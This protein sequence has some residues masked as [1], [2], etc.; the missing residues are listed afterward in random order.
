MNTT[1]VHSSAE[2]EMD[3]ICWGQRWEHHRVPRQVHT[4]ATCQPRAH[5]NP[6][7]SED[8]WPI[9]T[10]SPEASQVPAQVQPFRRHPTP[11]STSSPQARPWR[12]PGLQGAF[13][14]ASAKVGHSHRRKRTQARL[15]SLPEEPVT[16]PTAP[17]PQRLGP[18]RIHTLQPS[19]SVVTNY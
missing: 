7:C 4:P 19:K 17:E 6:V 12:G 9:P 16:E 15:Q 2:I 10:L 11:M 14:A 18:L 5:T 1:I 3:A 8:T 13:Q